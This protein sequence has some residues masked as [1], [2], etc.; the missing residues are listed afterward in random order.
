[1]ERV[2][3]SYKNRYGIELA[4][5]L[6]TPKGLDRS[7]KNAAVVIGAPYGGARSLR[8]RE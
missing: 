8:I 7:A 3:V 6:Y 5:E 4:G 2:D 1:M